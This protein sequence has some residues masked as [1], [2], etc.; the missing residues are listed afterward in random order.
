MLA[1]VICGI[2]SC[3]NPIAV[4]EGCEY[5]PIFQSIECKGFQPCEKLMGGQIHILRGEPYTIVLEEP[6]PNSEND[7]SGSCKVAY[8]LGRNRVYYW[9]IVDKE[10][11]FHGPLTAQNLDSLLKGQVYGGNR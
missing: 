7:T 5:D 2:T 3:S 6:N 9:L 4:T 11:K 10:K 8:P 1:L